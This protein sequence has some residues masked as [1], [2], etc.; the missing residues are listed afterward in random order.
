[1]VFSK[2]SIFFLPLSQF[3]SPG[4]S[5]KSLNPFNLKINYFS[6][7]YGEKTGAQV[8]A[9]NGFSMTSHSLSLSQRSFSTQVPGAR[10]QVPGAPGAPG[11]RCG[12]HSLSLSLSLSH[13][14]VWTSPIIIL[15]LLLRTK[16][17]K[18]NPLIS[19]SPNLSHT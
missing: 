19:L 14:Q 13:G 6:H 16:Y 2:E 10:C 8:S 5:L 1:M 15:L 12:F 18:A 7:A 17:R 4:V 11:A 9:A 3:K